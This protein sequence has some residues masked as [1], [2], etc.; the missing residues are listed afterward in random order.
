MKSAF[1][2]HVREDIFVYQKRYLKKKLEFYVAYH[3]N[4]QMNAR[5]KKRLLTRAIWR[6]N[7]LNP[8]NNVRPT[9]VACIDCIVECRQRA[10]RGRS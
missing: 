4:A 7:R 5:L 6:I 1:D 2:R 10:C 3:P 9:F 8:Q